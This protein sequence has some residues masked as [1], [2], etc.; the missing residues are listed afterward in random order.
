MGRG[1]RRLN[2]DDLSEPEYVDI[3]GV[4]FEVIPV[5]KKPIGRGELEKVSTLVQALPERKKL[6]ITFPRVE[7]YIMDVRQRIRIDWDKEPYLRVESQ[8]EPTEVEA[9][10]TV[11]YRVGVLTVWDPEK[12]CAKTA[13]LSI[14]TCD[15]KLPSMK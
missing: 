5:K 1:L 8:V 9:K 3:Y 12:P 11:G 13:I 14:S 15:F 4:P 7:G 2:Y 6:E 10:P